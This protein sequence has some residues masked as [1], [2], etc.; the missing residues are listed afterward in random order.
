MLPVCLQSE[1]SRAKHGS[2]LW[3]NIKKRYIFKKLVDN[4][5]QGTKSCDNKG[6]R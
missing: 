6:L 1:K 3:Q 2:F 5:I 4:I